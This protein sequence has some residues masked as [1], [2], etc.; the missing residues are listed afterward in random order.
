MPPATKQPPKPPPAAEP[1]QDN[2]A[3]LAAL[4]RLSGQVSQMQERLDLAEHGDTAGRS[5]AAAADD[6]AGPV[7]LPDDA[8]V[9]PG[10]V[11]LHRYFDPYAGAGGED[12]ARHALVVTVDQV[13]GQDGQPRRAARLAYLDP[14]D[15]V[16][17]DHLHL[18]G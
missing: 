17:F 10:D 3:L 5:A 12:I 16:S 7:G 2:A 18:R 4:N 8:D 1:A 6:P 13:P 11:V 9:Q 14:T 15:P